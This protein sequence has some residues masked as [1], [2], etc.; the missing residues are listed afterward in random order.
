MNFPLWPLRNYGDF[1]DNGI[2][3]KVQ[4][5]FAT[6]SWIKQGYG[7]TYRKKRNRQED[8]PALFN[9]TP[10]EI[11]EMNRNEGKYLA[12]V[13]IRWGF[14]EFIDNKLVPTEIWNNRAQYDE[15]G[16]KLVIKSKS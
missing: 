1:M 2:I 3:D 5:P 9:K 12:F 7:L 11:N 4:N 6:P 8:L 14:A 13:A 10:D 16:V 15:Y